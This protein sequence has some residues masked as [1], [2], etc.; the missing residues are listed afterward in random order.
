MAA[1]G[2][3][4]GL[5]LEDEVVYHILRR[6]IIQESTVY[7]SIWREAEE[8]KA[9]EIALNLFT[10]RRGHQPD[11]VFSWV[12]DRGSPTTAAAT[13]WVCTMLSLNSTRQEVA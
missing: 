12:R 2:I 3:L 4:A 8:E 11:C 1:P 13:T 10:R 6:N 9:Q 5:K 7:R